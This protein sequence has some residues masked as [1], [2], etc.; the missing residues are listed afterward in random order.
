MKMAMVGSPISISATC[1]LEATRRRMLSSTKK[2]AT[3]KTAQAV[4]TESSGASGI[5]MSLAVLALLLF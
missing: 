2:K 4:V 3:R 1:T 5:I